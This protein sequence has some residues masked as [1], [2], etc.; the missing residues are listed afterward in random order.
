MVCT[1]PSN[2]RPATARSKPRTR[3]FA[4]PQAAAEPFF[5]GRPRP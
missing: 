4:L 2:M 3:C 5:F 1:V